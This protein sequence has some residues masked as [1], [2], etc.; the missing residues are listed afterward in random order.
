MSQPIDLHTEVAAVVAIRWDKFAERHPNLA[1]VIDQHLLVESAVAALQNDPEYQ[2]VIASARAQGA[3][4]D[5]IIRL[6]DKYVIAWMA[7]LV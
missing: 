5:T 2:R 7:K 4:I 1:R 6:L 3:S